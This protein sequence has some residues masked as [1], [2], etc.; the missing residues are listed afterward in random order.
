MPAAATYAAEYRRCRARIDRRVSFLRRMRSE[1][2]CL[3]QI[4]RIRLK[5]FCLNQN[6]AIV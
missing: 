4:Q 1:A 6:L 3:Y 5:Q 2:I